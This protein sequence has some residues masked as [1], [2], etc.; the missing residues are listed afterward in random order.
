MK[1]SCLDSWS[2]VTSSGKS[3]KRMWILRN[4]KKY[5]AEE[6]ELLDTY[7][8]QIRSITEMACAVWN[9]GLTQQEVRGL[10]RVQK[11]H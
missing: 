10:E 7:F 6:Q 2:E 5:G 9:V 1:P 4:L 3:Y 11:L 8:Q